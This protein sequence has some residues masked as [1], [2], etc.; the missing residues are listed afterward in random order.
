M[1]PVQGVIGET[2]RKPVK[3]LGHGRITLPRKWLFT[4]TRSALLNSVDALQRLLM[5]SEV[6][7]KLFVG[8][9]RKAVPSRFSQGSEA[10][11][12]RQRYPRGSD[13][14]H[15]SDLIH[16][17]HVLVLLSRIICHGTV[18]IRVIPQKPAPCYPVIN[19]VSPGRASTI[20]MVSRLT[21]TIRPISSRM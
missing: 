2:I 14:D 1:K 21:V 16:P 20:L 6:Y 11:R 10:Q 3:R 17:G 19:Q 13:P 4:L 12:G 8:R 15:S 9:S 7:K 18:V 5:R